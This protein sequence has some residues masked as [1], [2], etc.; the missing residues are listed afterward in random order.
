MPHNLFSV[1][2]TWQVQEGLRGT[3]SEEV[4]KGLVGVGVLNSF[5]PGAR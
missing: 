3:L 5:K 1:D 4:K 2:S